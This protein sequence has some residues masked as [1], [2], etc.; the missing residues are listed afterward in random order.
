MFYVIV[1]KL[2]QVNEEL[3][4][5]IL[6]WNRADMKLYDHFNKTFWAEVDKYGR[7]RMEDDLKVFQ[8]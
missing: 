7:Q 2:P 1:I 8:V 6:K 4:E 5:K 3:G